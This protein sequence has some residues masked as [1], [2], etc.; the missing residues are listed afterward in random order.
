MD[1][2]DVSVIVASYNNETLLDQCMISLIKQS[3]KPE[4]YEIIVIDDCSTDDSPLILKNYADKVANLKVILKTVNEG[5]LFSRI[6]GMKLAQGRYVTFVDSDDWVSE[7]MCEII[8]NEF[9]NH[10]AD[11][12]EFGHIRETREESCMVRN[13]F[14]GERKP[15]EIV[16]L[17]T[18][19]KAN[20][21]VWLKAYKHEI[22][23]RTLEYCRHMLNKARYVGTNTDDE[24]LFPLFLNCTDR[25]YVSSEVYY[26]YRLNREGSITAMIEQDNLRRLKHAFTL[27]EAGSVAL[28]QVEWRKEYY[29]YY[30]F[31]QTNNIFYLL[32][33]ILQ[34]KV[35]LS[36]IDK[37]IVGEYIQEY[38]KIQARS[39]KWLTTNMIQNTKVAIRKG[40]LRL[41]L[42]RMR[43]ILLKT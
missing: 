26:H 11:M 7:D 10:H 25:Y 6:D 31:M 39:T 33:V 38:F 24:F 16:Q 36:E 4:R 42:Y 43:K 32:G 15:V 19:R 41:K 14:A 30:L 35:D 29:R 21:F 40:Q 9:Q 12:I 34:M 27:A 2:I 17:F 5:L 20:T 1:K 23:L 8:S 28:K 18:E 22:I 3:I 37:K 13:E